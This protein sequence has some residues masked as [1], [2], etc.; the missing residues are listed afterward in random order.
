MS[1]LH[2]FLPSPSMLPCLHRTVPRYLN[3]LTSS[4]LFSSNQ[5]LHFFGL[6]VLTLYGFSKSSLL[7]Y[8]L[9]HHYFTLAH[10]YFQTSP[11]AHSLNSSTILY[12][13]LLLSASKTVFLVNRVQSRQKHLP[14]W[15]QAT[16][17]EVNMENKRMLQAH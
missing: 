7:S 14:Q 13:V 2:F 1:P 4:I 17:G 9:K 12:G 3:S 5:T 11:S 8:P 10:I 16:P 15:A 6:S